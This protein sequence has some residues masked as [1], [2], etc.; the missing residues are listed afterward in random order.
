MKKNM[1]IG[2]IFLL[3]MAASLPFAAQAKVTTFCGFH[4]ND[5][6]QVVAQI[7]DGETLAVIAKGNRSG[8]HTWVSLEGIPSTYDSDNSSRPGAGGAFTFKKQITPKDEGSTLTFVFK[9]PWET[10]SVATC[11]VHIVKVIQ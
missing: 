6:R 10:T 11:T 9:R 3:T 8:G 7:T 1:L 5:T 2:S 4:G